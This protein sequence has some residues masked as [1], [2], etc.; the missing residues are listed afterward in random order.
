LTYNIVVE[1]TIAGTVSQEKID[2]MKKWMIDN[3]TKDSIWHIEI[4]KDSSDE[5][6]AQ[7]LFLSGEVIEQ[8]DIEMDIVDVD[9]IE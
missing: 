2:E 9:K 4:N 7:Y 5:D 3:D 8:E 1:K 6:I